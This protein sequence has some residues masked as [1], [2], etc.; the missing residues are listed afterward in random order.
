MTGRRLTFGDALLR[1]LPSIRCPAAGIGA[2]ITLFEKVQYASGM[3]GRR[4]NRDHN[5]WQ[6]VFPEWHR[7]CVRCCSVRRAPAALPQV[8]CAIACSSAIPSPVPRLS[9][10]SEP[11]WGIPIA[12][13]PSTRQASNWR[14][15][16]SMRAGIGR[17]NRFATTCS[18]ISAAPFSH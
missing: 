15:G 2:Q 17:L 5:S 16:N 14:R 6:F 7:T 12:I 3:T 11:H 4:A 13:D 9:E 10:R 1:Q 18:C 8:T